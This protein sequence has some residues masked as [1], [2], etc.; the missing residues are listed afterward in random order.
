MWV[1]VKKVWVEHL[2]LKKKKKKIGT[3]QRLNQE[4]LRKK[5]TIKKGVYLI[6]TGLLVIKNEIA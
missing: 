4:H 5:V 6:I 3:V 2:D 1:E